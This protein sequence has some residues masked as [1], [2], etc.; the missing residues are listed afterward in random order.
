MSESVKVPEKCLFCEDFHRCKLIEQRF[1][2]ICK[3]RP[4]TKEMKIVQEQPSSALDPLKSNFRSTNADNRINKKS[5]PVSVDN[6]HK[7][8]IIDE[9]KNGDGIA[10]IKGFVVFVH[11]TKI[12][13]EVKIKIKRVKTNCAF[14]VKADAIAKTYLRNSGPLIPHSTMT[15]FDGD[16]ITANPRSSSEKPR[17]RNGAKCG[18]CK[19]CGGTLVWD[20]KQ[21]RAFCERCGLEWK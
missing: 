12:G 20:S 18:K 9:G 7:V 21:S 6:I 17:N 11:D 1:T 3:K 5:P 4:K 8:K 2:D 19:E 15:T 14:A 13:D 16:L 10:K